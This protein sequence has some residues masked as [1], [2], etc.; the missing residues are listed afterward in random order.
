MPRIRVFESTA[1]RLALAHVGLFG[2]S[3]VV[4]V[5]VLYWATAG[6]MARQTD[7]TIAAEIRGLAEQYARRGTDGLVDVLAERIRKDPGGQAVYLLVGRRAEPLIGNLDRWPAVAPGADGW[8]VFDL[9][10]RSSGGAVHRARAR[11][12]VLEGGLRLLVGRDM[13]ETAAVERLIVR[14]LIWGGAATAIIG[15]LGGLLVARGSLRRLDTLNR[16][17]RDIIGGDLSRRLPSHGTGD[18]YDRLAETINDML[19]RI[20]ELMEASRQVASS[21]A[22]DLRTPLTRLRG[23]LEAIRDGADSDSSEGAIEGAIGEAD[24]LLATFNAILRIAEIDSRRRRA[25]FTEVDLVT[26]LSDL[27]D[28]YEPV[29]QDK[30]QSL[31]LEAPAACR[32]RGDRDLLFQ[33]LANLVDNAIKYA[34]EGGMIRV[35][36]TATEK[37]VAAYVADN[38]PGIPDTERDNVLRRFHRLAADRDTPGKGLGLSLSAAVARLHDGTI[39]LSDNHPGLVATLRLPQ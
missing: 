38:G 26:I 18:E 9:E 21:V 3:L 34:G 5:G 14:A 36:A 27:L 13:R 24:S 30:G 35:G 7:A 37:E 19:G 39:A 2:V 33:A 23:R 10:D 16:T 29:A 8:V 1:F 6:T 32:L 22:H 4:L 15:L 17:C 31:I 20:Q 28:L 11:V 25:G 12:F